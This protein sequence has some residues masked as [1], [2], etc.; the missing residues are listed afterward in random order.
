MP[1]TN[2]TT[3]GLSVA[4]PQWVKAELYDAL[5][6]KVRTLL[7]TELTAHRV[8]EIQV[9]SGNLPNGVYVLRVLG[10]LKGIEKRQRIIIQK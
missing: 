9:E 5:G 4:Q 8:H 7:D 1:F 6:R 10:S 2:T 3:V